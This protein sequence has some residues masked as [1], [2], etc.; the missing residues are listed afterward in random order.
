M[1]YP[2]VDTVGGR[3]FCLALL[4]LLVLQRLDG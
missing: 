4:L 2:I 3:P 1:T